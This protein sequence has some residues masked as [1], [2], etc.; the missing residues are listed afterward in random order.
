[1]RTSASCPSSQTTR[2][3]VEVFGWVSWRRGCGVIRRR[4]RRGSRRSGDGRVR[5]SVYIIRRVGTRRR[6]GHSRSNC[7]GRGNQRFPRLVPSE[8]ARVHNPPGFCVH[9]FETLTPVVIA[10]IEEIKLA[11]LAVQFALS[12]NAMVR[13]FA[14][15]QDRRRRAAPE[16]YLIRGEHAAVRLGRGA[17]ES[18]RGP[19]DRL[20]P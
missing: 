5:L 18:S 1:M 16:E 17:V 7:R 8:V 10:E 15:R 4:H 2:S 13:W 6:L 12:W 19:Q 3:G 20:H 9:D 11:R 14:E